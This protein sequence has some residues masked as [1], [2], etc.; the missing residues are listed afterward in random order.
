M[1][2]NN[3][4]ELVYKCLYIQCKAFYNDKL[5][6][7][8]HL[9]NSY[10]NN[11]VKVYSLKCPV[12]KCDFIIDDRESKEYCEKDDDLRLFLTHHMNLCHINI[13]AKALD[14][15]DEVNIIKN[16]QYNDITPISKDKLFNKNLIEDV[17]IKDLLSCNSELGK[18]LLKMHEGYCLIIK[19]GKYYKC[20]IWGCCMIFVSKK[21]YKL[22]I[23]RYKHLLSKIVN[24]NSNECTLNFNVLLEEL[25]YFKKVFAVSGI[26][27]FFGDENDFLGPILFKNDLTTDNSVVGCVYNSN[28]IVNNHIASAKS[29]LESINEETLSF[30]NIEI[31]FYKNTEYNDLSASIGSGLFYRNIKECI[32]HCLFV[33]IKNPLF[34]VCTKDNFT[35]DFFYKFES[36]SA[37]IYF[38]DLSLKI[39]DKFEFNFGFVRKM[40]VDTKENSLSV[41]ILFSDGVIRKFNFKDKNYDFIPLDVFNIIDFEVME[42]DT[43]ICTDGK[44]LFKCVKTKIVKQSDFFDSFINSICIRTNVQDN[45]LLPP[46]ECDNMLTDLKTKTSTNIVCC[47]TVNGYIYSVDTNLKNRLSLLKS[48]YTH[49]IIYLQEDDE[50]LYT[51]QL[52][53]ATKLLTIEKTYTKTKTLKNS[54]FYSVCRSKTGLIFGQYDGQL[55]FLRKNRKKAQPKNLFYFVKKGSYFLIL[56]KQED[57]NTVDLTDNKCLIINILRYD[58]HIYLFFKCGII[59][60]FFSSK[61]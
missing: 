30:E 18:M 20:K 49:K 24:I 46:L 32:T 5:D 48:F 6:L 11:N 58:K 43:I 2:K 56:D 60:K 23:L 4:E 27:Q 44:L 12:K 61:L 55:I 31:I 59:L 40:I 57:I 25:N 38:L 51:N 28:G 21:A 34:L 39:L 17:Y 41:F 47:S 50:I 37:R 19:E 8:N 22:H 1:D 14:V 36:C 54:L 13:L 15:F 35:P 10:H 52:G 3:K 9:I 33:K 45:S 29:I 26:I 16:K 42:K 53:L 7:D